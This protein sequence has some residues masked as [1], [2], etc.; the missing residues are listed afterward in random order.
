M[1]SY[2][3]H[4]TAALAV[5]ALALACGQPQKQPAHSSVAASEPEPQRPFNK[6][7]VEKPYDPLASTFEPPTPQQST[8]E[9]PTAQAPIEKPLPQ[10]PF[11]GPGTTSPEDRER[12]KAKAEK[13]LTDGE[14]IG[15]AMAANEGEVKMAEVALK[16]AVAHDVKKFAERMKSDHGKALKQDKA[17]EKKAKIAGAE[18]DV[19]AA[20]KAD[21]AKTVEELHTKS[22]TAFDRAYMASQVKAHKELLTSID[23]RL[24]PSAQHAD[25]KAMLVEMRRTVADHLASAEEIQKKTEQAV[26]SSR[27]PGVVEPKEK[28]PSEPAGKQQDQSKARTPTPTPVEKP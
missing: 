8:L 5:A 27:I 28:I 13:R 18:S 7:R 23:D 25:V 17:L 4:G 19:S 22:G 20:L 2:V 21:V 15:A 16:K 6:P 26:S 10:K 3:K 14:V 11:Y 1:I 9:P 24:M 12:A